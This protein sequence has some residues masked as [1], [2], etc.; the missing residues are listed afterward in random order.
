MRSSDNHHHAPTKRAGFTLVELMIASGVA[1][2]V[3]A[4][5]ANGFIQ[6]RRTHHQKNLEQEL[7]QN[8]RTA[9]TFLQRDLRYAGSGMVM[10]T[11][12]APKWFSSVEW[13]PKGMNTVPWVVN[14]GLRGTDELYLIG[15]AGEA[16]GH[17]SEDVWEGG[18]ELPLTLKQETLLPYQPRFGDVLLISGLEA[19]VVESVLGLNRVQVTRDPNT[20][21]VGVH[22]IYP[23][24]TEVHQFSAIRY[25]VQEVEGVPSL[26]REDSR[27]TYASDEDRVVA[28]GIEHFK[29]TRNGH[30]FEIEL[31]G[32][33]R[34][35]APGRGLS[36][37]LVRY[38]MTSSNRLRNPNPR[39]SIQGWP[40]DL[41]IEGW[42]YYE[43]DFGDSGETGDDDVAG[44]SD[45][46]GS[47]G[48]DEI[49]NEEGH[50][51]KRK[52]RGRK[53]NQGQGNN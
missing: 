2:V 21:T 46:G 22:L 20:P 45:G 35:T 6:Q 23:E 11:D 15:I 4:A 17:L 10:G 44:A 41:L 43:D 30:L 25:W 52:I 19:V 53:G 24:G 29:I 33:S 36:D 18:R 31:R 39:L 50:E 37:S 12:S 34:R 3:L 16:I 47:S 27:F 38:E 5:F 42:E 28:D 32:R 40:S 48:G 49:F 51:P 7:Q 26:L 1:T 13:L 14:G 9:M 8:V